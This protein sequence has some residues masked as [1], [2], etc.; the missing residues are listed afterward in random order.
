MPHRRRSGKPG[1]SSADREGF[2]KP[3]GEVGRGHAGTV[4]GL[5]ISRLARNS[6]DGHRLPEICALTDALILDEDS[7][8]SLGDFNDR[9][10]LGLNGTR[11]DA[12]L[13]VLRAAERRHPQS[14]APRR[15]EDTVEGC[16]QS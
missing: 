13:H 2:Q 12:E 1:A 3:G 16:R 7:I 15:A 14:G 5:E 9:L 6:T 11:S 10:L 4:L 8:Y